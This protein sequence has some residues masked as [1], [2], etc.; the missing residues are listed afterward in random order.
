M[1]KSGHTEFTPQPNFTFIHSFFLS[2][3]VLSTI[4]GQFMTRNYRKMSSPRNDVGKDAATNLCKDVFLASPFLLQIFENISS[5][6]SFG[7]IDFVE[8][9]FICCCGSISKKV[10]PLQNKEWSQRDILLLIYSLR[11]CVQIIFTSF[12]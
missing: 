2:A 1:S 11:H 9:K 4:G 7:G 5:S 10:V 3:L 6:S 12:A 8:E